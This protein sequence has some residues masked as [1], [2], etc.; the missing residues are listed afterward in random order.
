MQKKA[1]LSPR[2]A[3]VRLCYLAL[4][5][6]MSVTL[7]YVAKMIFGT[8]PLR[9]TFENLP[10]VFAGIVFGPISGGIVGAVADLVNCLFAGQAPILLIT[11]GAM[12][13]G[14]LSGLLSH[15]L[16]KKPTYVNLLT[17]ELLTQ[18]IASVIV[19]SLAL[20]LYFSYSYILLLPRLPI[21]IGIAIAESYC[22]YILFNH[23]AIKKHLPTRKGE[24]HT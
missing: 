23:P 19:K 3:I 14:V 10:I 8:S 4:L 21:Y 9:V 1:P 22:L 11:L 18:G 5:C 12:L 15:S 7:G 6:A 24:D 16:W 13:V 20:H 17:V 2:N